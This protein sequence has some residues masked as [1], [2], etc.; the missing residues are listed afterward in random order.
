M[1]LPYYDWN[2]QTTK[3]FE[4]PDEMFVDFLTFILTSKRWQEDRWL[5]EDRVSRLQ[6]QMAE[7]RNLKLHEMKLQE[8]VDNDEVKV[9]KERALAADRL[10][11]ELLGIT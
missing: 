8:A 3:E 11:A 2:A 10:A 4:Y 6:G 5:V 7:Y 9:R 1:K